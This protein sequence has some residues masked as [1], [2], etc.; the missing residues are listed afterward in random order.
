MEQCFICW[1][2]FLDLIQLACDS[3]CTPLDTIS[4]WAVIL[5]VISHVRKDHTILQRGLSV[6]L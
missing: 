6:R 2:C 5:A 1:E 4:I 3:L